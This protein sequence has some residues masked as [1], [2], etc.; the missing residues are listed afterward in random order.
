MT[1]RTACLILLI[2]VGL[3]GPLWSQEDTRQTTQEPQQL[4]AQQEELD[5]EGGSQEDIIELGEVEIT[6]Q[7]MRTGA[8]LMDAGVQVIDLSESVRQAQGSLGEVLSWE[9]GISS[10]FYGAGASRPIVRGMDGYR[11]GVFDAGLSTGDLS[12]SSPDHAVAIE[13]LFVRSITVYRGAAALV[14][15]G[16]AIGGAIDTEPDFLPSRETPKGWQGELGMI[17]ETVNDGR[18][19]YLKAGHRGDLFALRVNLLARETEDYDIPGFARTE[20]YDRSNF[21]RLPPSVRGQ[22]APN[23]EGIVPN[24]GTQTQV[25]AMGVGWFQPS[26]SVKATYQY[27]ASEYGVPLDGHSHGNPFG[28]PGVT[29]PGPRDA[30]IIDLEQNRFLFQGEVTPDLDWI[31]S[32]QLKSAFTEFHQIENEGI[33]LSNDFQKEGGEIHL[34]GAKDFGRGVITVGLEFAEEGY[35]NRN[36]SYDAGRADEDFLENSSEIAAAYAVSEVTFGNTTLRLGGRW[37]YQ[38]TAR[39]DE[40]NFAQNSGVPISRSDHAGGIVGEVS[41][42][43]RQHWEAVL[44]LSQ[45]ARLPNAE[46]LVIEAPH[47]AIGAFLIGN[48]FLSEESSHSAEILLRRTGPKFHL[49]ASAYVDEFEGYIFLEN[50]GYEVD[51]LTAYMYTQRDARFYGGEVAARWDFLSQSAWQGHIEAFADY[52]HA[53]GTENDDPLPRI[54]PWRLGGHLELSHEAWRGKVSALHAFQQDRV[55][56]SIFGTLAYQ[57]PSEAYTLIT[58]HLERGFTL[59]QIDFTA[60]AQV[61]NLLDEEAR[62]HTSFLKDVA[63]LPG[64]S[65][66]LTIRAEF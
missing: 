44:S 3:G 21:I 30:V 35:T 31:D 38:Q 7:R 53:T 33:F 54:P 13:P 66:Q 52:V 16:E 6:A 26:W 65:L 63:P 14:H 18:T 57:S 8:D 56:R 40:V 51:G 9:P 5:R 27:Y 10:S 43:F 28:E 32:L 50:Q 45:T 55:P 20:D 48:P 17:V 4:E 49:S 29:G 46:E 23:S 47:G 2:L 61:S 22:V 41:Q 34:E 15:G 42:V 60:T 62:Q 64:R 59:G 58:L 36:I 11:V 24:T 12:A 1:S 25:V 19:A 39:E 37:D